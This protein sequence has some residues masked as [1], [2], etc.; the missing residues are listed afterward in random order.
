MGRV[1][2]AALGALA[3]VAV[4]YAATVTGRGPTIV[5]VPGGDPVNPQE[6]YDPFE[7]GEDLPSG[8]RQ[9][10]RRDVI[11]PVYDPSYVPAAQSG[12]EDDLLVIGVEFDG[13]ARAYPVSFLNRREMVIDRIAGIPV[14]VTW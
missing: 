9:L 3:L 14:L 7:A 2:I 8:Y 11:A 4:V 5:S 12:W 6:V 10:L 1:G 13:D